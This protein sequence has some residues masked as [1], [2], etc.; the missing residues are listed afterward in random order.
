MSWYVGQ[1]VKIYYNFLEKSPILGRVDSLNY[2][3][4]RGKQLLVI[5]DAGGKFL[6]YDSGK[7]NEMDFITPNL[8]HLFEEDV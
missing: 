2:P 3:Y 7:N 4:H 1:R 8:E 5:S 6:Y